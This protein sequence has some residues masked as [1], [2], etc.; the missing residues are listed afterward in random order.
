MTRKSIIISTI[1]KDRQADGEKEKCKA[2]TE[3]EG[4]LERE[5]EKERGSLTHVLPGVRG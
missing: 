5:R 1:S 3:K 2:E 4:N